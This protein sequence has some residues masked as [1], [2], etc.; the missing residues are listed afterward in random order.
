MNKER[1]LS[2]LKDAKDILN[3][4][5]ASFISLDKFLSEKKIA[6]NV[7]YDYGMGGILICSEKD[8][9]VEFTKRLNT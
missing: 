9:N 7:I 8:G 4:L 6:F 3:S 1:A 2:D 5:K